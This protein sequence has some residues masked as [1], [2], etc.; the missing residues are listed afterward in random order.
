MASPRIALALTF[1]LLALAG[2]DKSEKSGN[3]ETFA[4]RSQC[5]DLGEKLLAGGVHGD[6]VRAAQKTNYSA[7][8]N[9]CYVEITFVTADAGA[10]DYKSMRYLYDGQSKQVL[11]WTRMDRQGSGAE[12]MSCSMDENANLGSQQPNSGSDCVYINSKINEALRD[13]R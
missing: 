3:A 7:L 5:A 9:R 13:T 2:C 4:L 12:Q 8:N 10:P 11:A 1:S 6:D